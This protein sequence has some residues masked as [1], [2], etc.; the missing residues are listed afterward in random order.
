MALTPFSRLALAICLPM[1]ASASDWPQFLGP[2]RDAVYLGPALAD[3]WP[4]D[5]PPVVWRSEVG[6]GYSSPVVSE[7]R[8]ILAQRSENKLIVN[9]YEALTGRT[10]WSSQFPMKFKDLEGRDS[11]PRPTPSIKGDRVFVCNT[12]GFLACLDLKDGS[13]VWSRQTKAEFKT[14]ATW[15]GYISSPLV[16]E[17]AVIAVIGGTNSAGVVAFDRATGSVLWKTLRDQA[18]A[19]S[20]MLATFSGKSELIVITRVAIRA[21]DPETGHEYW[22]LPTRR[23]TTGDIYAAGPVVFGDRLFISGCYRLGAQLLQIE[24][25][26][27][28]KLWH[29]DDALST[30]LACAIYDDGFLYGFHGHAGLPEGRTFRCIEAATGKVVWEQTLAGAGTVVRAGENLLIS[31]DTG[32]L[33]LARATPKGL[34]IKS[35]AQIAGKPTRS[36]PAIADGYAFL[37][38]PKTLVCLDLRAGK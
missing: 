36:Y 13:T 21:L 2:T 12:D 34:Q 37:R 23:Q 29:L 38:G 1:G 25:G 17:R 32:E 28:K 22:N 31:L 16:T 5:G 14:S 26:L 30:H 24:N 11:G 33:L 35:R 4:Q 7:G 20:P 3:K 15:H 19:P 8:L 27:P 9:C 18:S 6:E 10:N